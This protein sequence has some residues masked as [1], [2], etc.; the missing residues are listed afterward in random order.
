MTTGKGTTP[1]YVLR[2]ILTENGVDPD[3]DV[4]LDFYSE[5]TEAL[6]QLQAG[7]STIAMLPQPFVTSA[8]AQVEGLRVAWI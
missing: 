3:N 1:E 4:T 6:A 2:Y 8:L 5:A 7:T